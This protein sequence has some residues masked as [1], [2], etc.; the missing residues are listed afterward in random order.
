VLPPRWSGAGGHLAVAELASGAPPEGCARRSRQRSGATTC[1]RRSL[2]CSC[3]TYSTPV[4]VAIEWSRLP[5]QVAEC[6]AASQKTAKL[7]G[8]TA[9]GSRSRRRDRLR[10]VRCGLLVGGRVLPRTAVPRRARSGSRARRTGDRRATGQFQQLLPGCR[11]TIRR[12]RRSAGRAFGNQFA[13]AAL[14][15]SSRSQG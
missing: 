8:A 2:G 13:V 4:A 3:H 5:L 9:A 15:G 6:E 1:P 10:R 12:L 11:G 14:D 7:D